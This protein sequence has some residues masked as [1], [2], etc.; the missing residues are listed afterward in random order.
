[1]KKL[2]SFATASLILFSVACKKD[3]DTATSPGSWKVG[4]NTYNVAF[5]NRIGTDGP[6]SQYMFTFTDPEPSGSVG[7][8]YF[9]IVFK[10]KPTAGTYELIGGTGNASLTNTQCEIT[11]ANSDASYAYGYTKANAK[12]VEVSLS[13]GKTKITIPEISLTSPASAGFVDVK[14]SATVQEKQ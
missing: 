8:N 12:I 4:S 5:S 11:V 10:S 14:F 6:D 7:V 9:T 3:N 1:M 2:L 13:R